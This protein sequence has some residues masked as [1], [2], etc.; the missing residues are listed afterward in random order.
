MESLGAHLRRQ[1][2]R[3]GLSL[4]DVRRLTGISKPY[5]SLVETGK[6]RSPP[7]DEKLRK[8]EEVLRFPPGSLLARAHWAKTPADVR[9]AVGRLLGVVGVG[10]ACA[11]GDPSR[12]AAGGT[13]VACG[14]RSSGARALPAG[15]GGTAA[16]WASLDE[17][18]RS[19]ALA[20][21]VES[22]AGNV[23]PAAWERVPLINRVSAGYPQDF[24]DLGYPARVADSDVPAPA[25]GERDRFAARVCGE[26]MLP[27]YADGDVV[28]FSPQAAVE[29][30]ADCFVRLE[31]G[32]TTFKRVFFEQDAKGE[33]VVRLQPL[34]P[35]FAPT[36][37]P[38]SQVAGVYRAVWLSRAVGAA[39]PG[40][41]AKADAA[42]AGSARA[43]AP[44]PRAHGSRETRT[45]RSRTGGG[46]GAAGEEAGRR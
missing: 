12:P 11:G 20:A 10:G 34:N 14:N 5:L 4:D 40:D 25:S 19:G 6:T 2:R 15:S 44:A 7:S 37:V 39:V 9:A 22:R 26:S 29:S 30:G 24:T 43:D 18:Y 41:V 1:R 42:R 35:R 33:A 16:A 32:Q 46:G 8:L 3:L 21:W 23:E 38:A 28:V 27:A 36:V 45:G 31:D 17:L 13:D